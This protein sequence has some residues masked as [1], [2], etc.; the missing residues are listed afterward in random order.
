M[1]LKKKKIMNMLKFHSRIIKV[2][3]IIELH[4]NV[5]KKNKKINFYVGIKKIMTIR[6]VRMRIM[7]MIKTI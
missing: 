3:K 5:I 6:E 4:G 1:S 7:K 2:M